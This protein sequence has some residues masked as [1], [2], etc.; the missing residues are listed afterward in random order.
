MT[1]ITM[2][3]MLPMTPSHRASR[4]DAAADWKLQS[5]ARRTSRQ[6]STIGPWLATSDTF[7]NCNLLSSTLSL[8]A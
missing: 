2:G 8:F 7:K 3:P 6:M 5:I 4:D 1:Y